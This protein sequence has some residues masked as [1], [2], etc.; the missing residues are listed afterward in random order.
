MEN[1]TLVY[2]IQPIGSKHSDSSLCY[3]LSFEDVAVKRTDFLHELSLTDAAIELSGKSFEVLVDSA[4]RILEANE[5]LKLISALAR[6]CESCPQGNDC[7]Q[8]KIKEHNF[9]LDLW[10]IQELLFRANAA[11]QKLANQEA[12]NCERQLPSVLHGEAPSVNTEWLGETNGEGMLAVT[13]HETLNQGPA[14]NS[15]PVLHH[16]HVKPKGLLGYLRNCTYDSV[17]GH[18]TVETGE[19]AGLPSRI[20]REGVMNATA[21]Y[22]LSRPPQQADIEIWEKLII[23]AKEQ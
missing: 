22:T 14:K 13:G 23:E 12:W 4:G 15:L 10:S 20:S 8:L 2:L 18:I 19:S 3:R 1:L 21:Y 6:G 7:G 16:P 9:L 11:L 17:K 5:L